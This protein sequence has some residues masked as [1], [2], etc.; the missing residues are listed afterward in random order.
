MRLRPFCAKHGNGL[1][2]HLLDEFRALA[3]LKFREEKLVTGYSYWRGTKRVLKL[4][5]YQDR[6]FIELNFNI[7]LTEGLLVLSEEDAKLLGTGRVR[8]CYVGAD[9]EKAKEIIKMA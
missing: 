6:F 7:S 4:A 1:P 5:T 3:G 8:Q 9:V 2:I